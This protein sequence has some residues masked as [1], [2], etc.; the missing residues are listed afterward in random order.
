MLRVSSVSSEAGVQVAA[1]A[2]SAEVG[3][4]AARA[5]SAAAAHFHRLAVA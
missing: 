1:V 3:R 4:V 5:D 2:P